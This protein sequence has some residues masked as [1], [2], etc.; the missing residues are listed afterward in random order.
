MLQKLG[1]DAVWIGIGLVDLVDRHDDRHA[2]GF[3][4][5]DGFDGLRHDAVIG[6]NAK[7]HDIRDPG[8][9]GAHIGKG[10]VARRVDKANLG[11]RRHGYLIGA[12]MLGDAAFFLPGHV[13]FTER[14][15]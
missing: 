1:S 12:D 3:G 5:V 11:A 4:V 7:H 14:V 6:G 8:A 15:Q 2:G 13:R 10:L 9:P